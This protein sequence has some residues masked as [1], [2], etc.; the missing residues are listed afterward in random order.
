MKTFF[1]TATLAALAAFPAHALSIKNLSGTTQALVL[2]QGG[3]RMELILG[4]GQTRYLQGGPYIAHLPGQPSK[5]VKFDEEYVI[6]PSGKM[7]IQRRLKAAG[8]SL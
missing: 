5:E 1:L 4:A 7:H 3:N 6:W 2:E 8:A